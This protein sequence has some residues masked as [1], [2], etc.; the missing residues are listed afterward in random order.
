MKIL[1]VVNMQDL[2]FEEPLG[3]LYLSAVCKKAGYSTFSVENKPGKVE[4]AIESIKPDM[5]GFSVLTTDFP[6]IY[7]SA[8]AL[9]AKYPSVAT[10]FGGP[11][12]TYFPEIVQEAGI[13]F[14][15]R[16][17]GEE[18]FK[19]FLSCFSAGKSY[20][21]VN[22]LVFKKNG[23]FQQNPVRPLIDNL[24]S[25]SFPDRELFFSHK[26]FYEADVRSV[27]ASRGCPNQCSYCYNHQNRL[28]Y[29]G[30][31][32][33]YRARSVD[34]VIAE[35]AELK[36]KYKAKMLHFFDDIFPF[37]A[38]WVEDFTRKYIKDVG[39]PFMANT[40]FNVC[41]QHYVSN[42]AKAGCK[43]F[44]IG[45]ETGNQYF[46]KQVLFRQV[47]NKDMVERAKLVHSHGIKI[48]T[49]NLL[50]IPHGSLELDIETLRRN[51]QIEADY[52]GA[53]Q[54]QPYPGTA[55]EKIAKQANLMDSSKDFSRSFYSASNLMIEDKEKVAKLGVL[56][57]IVVN[58]PFLLNFIYLFLNLPL[59]PW[60][61]IG[62]LLHG[63]KIKTSM[64]RYKMGPRVFLKNVMLYF[65]RGINRIFS[66]EE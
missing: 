47:S 46:S 51:I 16:G 62:T 17:E 6:V 55:I 45:V 64:L 42:L 15:V 35:C 22:S 54:C 56:F 28:L 66:Q 4:S 18:S 43:L 30:L 9:K 32:K 63:Y 11:H 10:V 1:F 61:L 21:D 29:K 33:H 37:D 25:I 57:P 3:I 8:K 5:L 49:Q 34:N 2:G 36:S 60:R 23:S 41:S 14:A 44:F 39:L 31:G 13:D 38:A 58:F 26:Q 12:A 27:M 20:E 65:S 59:L 53:Y 19:E 50:G 52:A 7:S 40:H 48:Y 24:D